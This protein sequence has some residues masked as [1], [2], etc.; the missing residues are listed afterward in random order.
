[1]QKINNIPALRFFRKSLRNGLTPAEAKLWLHLKQ[2]Q[3]QGR[4]FRRQHSVG[5]YI[6]DFYCPAE[7]LAVELDGAAHDSIDAREYDRERD[8]FI[9]CFEIKVLRFEN[10]WVFL[11]TEAVLMEIQRHFGWLA[12]TTPPQTTPPLRG[13][14]P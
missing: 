10:Q 13:T 2:S 7:R 9:A 14:P 3:L 6:L 5:P 1:M 8:L 11:E 12:E 4:K